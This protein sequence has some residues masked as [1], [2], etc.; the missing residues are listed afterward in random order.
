MRTAEQVQHAHDKQLMRAAGLVTG[1]QRP[2]TSKGTIFVT[3]E[4]ETGFV[5]VIVRP[6]LFARQRK[7]VLLSR[8]L[9]VTGHIERQGDVIHLVAGRLSDQTNLLSDLAFRSRDFH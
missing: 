2:E 6:A 8:L 7:E 3:I 5:N 9:C 1:R 4:D